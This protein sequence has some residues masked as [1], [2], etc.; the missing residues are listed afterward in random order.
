LA[1]IFTSLQVFEYINA[2]FNIS[3]SVYG[4]VFYLSTGFHGLHVIVGTIFLVVCLF[5]LYS[6]HFTQ[7]HHFGF[8]AAAWY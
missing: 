1:L 2:N 4:S 5:R 6:H 3:D 8:E 7:T